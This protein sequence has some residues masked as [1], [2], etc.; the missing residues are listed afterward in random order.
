MEKRNCI[1][2]ILRCLKSHLLSQQMENYSQHH[3]AYVWIGV[4]SHD[5]QTNNIVLTILYLLIRYATD[6]NVSVIFAHANVSFGVKLFK[7]EIT[8]VTSIHGLCLIGVNIYYLPLD[9]YCKFSITDACNTKCLT[10]SKKVKYYQVH[11]NTCHRAQNV[12]IM[13]QSNASIFANWLHTTATQLPSNWLFDSKRIQIKRFR[14]QWQIISHYCSLCVCDLYGKFIQMI[15][16]HVWD[17]CMEMHSHSPPTLLYS[18]LLNQTLTKVLPNW[19][20]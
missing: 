4:V 20:T 7:F 14:L 10:C 5:I 2:Y 11:C 3:G 12:P 1:Q 16:I 18:R 19:L 6:A 15:L 13:N 8:V 9:K 17:H